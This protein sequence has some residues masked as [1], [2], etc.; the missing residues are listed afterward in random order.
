[1][2]TAQRLIGR[3]RADLEFRDVHELVQEDVH[4]FLARVHE[5]VHMVADAVAS[6]FFRLGATLQLYAVSEG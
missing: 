5:G 6:Q 1:V 4:G 3:L 2:A